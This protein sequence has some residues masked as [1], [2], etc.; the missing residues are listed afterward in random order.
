MLEKCNKTTSPPRKKKQMVGEYKKNDDNEYKVYKVW[1]F[2][3]VFFLAFG[4]K[5]K[6]SNPA[7]KFLP[8]PVG[9]AKNKLQNKVLGSSLSKALKPLATPK[10]RTVFIPPSWDKERQTWKQ[11]KPKR[12]KQTNYFSGHLFRTTSK[13]RRPN[14]CTRNCQKSLWHFEGQRISKI[15]IL[16][17]V[18]NNLT[19]IGKRHLKADR[20]S[21]LTKHYKYK[22]LEP[23]KTDGPLIP[24]R[25]GPLLKE[26]TTT[27]TT[28]TARPSCGWQSLTGHVHLS[29]PIHLRQ[30]RLHLGAS[31]SKW[32]VDIIVRVMRIK[33]TIATNIMTN[34]F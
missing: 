29:G 19:T 26:R 2:I 34:N 23:L 33:R 17:L 31:F 4:P 25:E 14:F 6:N 30:H 12:A 20:S 11:S 13:N 8:P 27:V 21:S 5:A 32:S 18:Q 15:L 1:M 24:A 16:A 3:S 7:P 10:N 28:W 9:G 22:H